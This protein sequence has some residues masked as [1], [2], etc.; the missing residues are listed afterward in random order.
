ML[1]THVFFKQFFKFKFQPRTT[2]TEIKIAF[3]ALKF[4]LFAQKTSPFKFAPKTQQTF[5]ATPLQIQ[6]SILSSQR[7]R[8]FTHTDICKQRSVS[9]SIEV[10]NSAKRS[11]RELVRS[12]A[13]STKPANDKRP[14][15]LRLKIQVHYK[16]LMQTHFAFNLLFLQIS[17]ANILC[18]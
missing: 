3:S 14:S 15:A 4:K 16:F 1:S 10:L 6:I 7:E 18:I 9:C 5:A 2:S 13:P 17:N 12:T 8:N 11:C